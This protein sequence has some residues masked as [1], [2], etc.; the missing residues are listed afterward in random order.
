MLKIGVIILNYLAYKTTIDT[1][2]SF[3]NQN[4]NGCQI[5]YVIVDN[6]SSNDSF[7]VLKKEYKLHSNIH[8]VKTDSNLG[9]AR[10]NNFGYNEL[11]KIINPDFVIVSNDDI[12]LPKEGLYEWI[13]KAYK[14]YN[15][16]VLGPDIYSIKGKYHQNPMNNFSTKRAI[17]KKILKNFYRNYY[18]LKIRK[19]LGKKEINVY[20]SWK[21]NNYLW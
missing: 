15:F 20:P 2:N 18:S 13:E 17:C 19:L 4:S 16:A 7:E 14:K 5:E 10:G 21:N 3:L 1:V 9:F 8:V 6:F 11:I 12:L